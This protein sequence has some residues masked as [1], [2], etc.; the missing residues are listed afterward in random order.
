MLTGCWLA[1]VKNDLWHNLS[2][3]DATKLAVDKP[4]CW[5][6]LATSGATQW[7][8]ATWTMMMMMF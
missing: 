6:L 4:L 5:R 8:G 1:K 7:N 3:E 2:V